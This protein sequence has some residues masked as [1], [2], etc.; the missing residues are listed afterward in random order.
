MNITY[1]PNVDILTIVLDDAEI[2]ESDGDTEGIIM[3]YD[4]A[5]KLVGIEILDASKRVDNPYMMPSVSPSLS[6]ISA[7]SRT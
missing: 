2:D 1:D 5:G 7:S 6:S 3:D 4:F